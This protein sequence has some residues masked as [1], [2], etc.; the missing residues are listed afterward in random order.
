MSK[1]IWLP[2]FISVVLGV[3]GWLALTIF[4]MNG[5]LSK[6]DTQ[7]ARVVP[8]AD[9]FPILTSKLTSTVKRVDKIAEYLPLLQIKLAKEEL[10]K[11]VRTAIVATVPRKN[12]KGTWEV[13]INVYD[14]D[15]SKNTSYLIPVKNSKDKTPLYT[16]L[17]A[18]A[19]NEPIYCSLRTILFWSSETGKPAVIPAGIDPKASIAL[20]NTTAEQL[21]KEL[22]WTNLQ[23]KETRIE[24]KVTDTKSLMSFVQNNAETFQLVQ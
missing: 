15:R 16:A 5:T 18:A 9:Q 10:S 2:I 13:V 21:I 4:N 23:A 14:V 20:R 8:M 19:H 7:V 1:S 12:A 3:L 24:A 17:G 6:V 22:P 11:I